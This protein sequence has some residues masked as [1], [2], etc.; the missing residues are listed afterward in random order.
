VKLQSQLPCCPPV[1]PEGRA[2][3]GTGLTGPPPWASLPTDQ[4]ILFPF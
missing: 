1:T 4:Y 3:H 2:G